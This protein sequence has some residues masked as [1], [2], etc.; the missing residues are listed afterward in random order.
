RLDLALRDVGVERRTLVAVLA[1]RRFGAGVTRRIASSPAR[2]DSSGVL[3]L[4]L[5]LMTTTA[6][7]TTPPPTTPPASTTPPS[8]TTPPASTTPTSPTTP[9]APPPPPPTPTTASTAA[10]HR[11]VLLVLDVAGSADD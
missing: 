9:P 2:C 6:P 7:S 11:D 3:A 4:L 1:S 5:S 10:H 8:P